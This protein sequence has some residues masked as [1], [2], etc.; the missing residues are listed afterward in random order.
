MID[1]RVFKGRRAEREASLKI[2]N[3]SNGEKKV[4]GTLYSSIGAL[5][6]KQLG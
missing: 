4:E 6:V 2:K 1:D 3:A 5:M